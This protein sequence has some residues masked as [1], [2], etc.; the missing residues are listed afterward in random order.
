MQPSQIVRDQLWGRVGYQP[1]AEQRA[2]HDSKARI[3][4]IAGG[5]R[6]GKSRSAAMELVGRFLEGK[7]YWLYDRFGAVYRPEPRQSI[8][9]R[10]TW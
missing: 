2:A 1:F 3:R 5:E 7:L 10:I 9:F 6:A 4:L 8:P